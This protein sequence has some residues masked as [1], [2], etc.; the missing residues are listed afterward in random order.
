MCLFSL[1][2]VADPTAEI[3]FNVDLGVNFV[4]PHPPNAGTKP[5]F[6]REEVG[7]VSFKGNSMYGIQFRSF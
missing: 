6:D 7:S 4:F 2:E 3:S 1:A 5:V